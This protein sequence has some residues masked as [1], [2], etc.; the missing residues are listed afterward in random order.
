MLS[1]SHAVI[2]FMVGELGSPG[3]LGEQMAHFIYRL[4]KQICNCKSGQG[5]APGQHT[6]L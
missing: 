6:P 2:L 4:N 5:G 1:I 3:W